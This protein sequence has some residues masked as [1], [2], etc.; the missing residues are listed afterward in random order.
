MKRW[1]IGC[2]LVVVFL[3]EFLFD[4]LLSSEGE[5]GRVESETMLFYIFSVPLII[6]TFAFYC[7]FFS[8][9]PFVKF[10]FV[11][12]ACFVYNFRFSSFSSF[13]SFC[14]LLIVTP[15]VDHFP[16]PTLHCWLSG[17]TL[18]ISNIDQTGFSS[19]VR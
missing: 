8:F 12:F 1:I 9:V 18:V 4:T 5:W 15:F 3:P 19:E 13:S 2:R 11:C 7:S 17:R 14:S 16:Y 6:S 10:F